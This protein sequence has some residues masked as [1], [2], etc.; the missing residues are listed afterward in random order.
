MFE[1]KL[2]L[3][4]QEALDAI[5]NDLKTYENQPE[6]RYYMHSYICAAAGIPYKAS[7]IQGVSLFL[8]DLVKEH[9]VTRC[10]MLV[11]NVAGIPS[12]V[13]SKE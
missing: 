7:D 2:F 4:Y 3:T 1:K 5:I 12:L 6:I 10:L 13:A 9:G 8:Q 11:G